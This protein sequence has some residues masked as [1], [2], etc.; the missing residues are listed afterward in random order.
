MAIPATASIDWG[1]MFDNGS[2]LLRSVAKHQTTTSVYWPSAQKSLPINFISS[3]EPVLKTPL[4]KAWCGWLPNRFRSLHKC[5][6]STGSTSKTY[7]RL[8]RSTRLFKFH[9]PVDSTRLHRQ[10]IYSVGRFDR[11]RGLHQRD[12]MFWLIGP[13]RNSTA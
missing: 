3:A 12:G 2:G 9:W 5:W 4:T 8:D 1:W 6:K 13:W 10:T 7:D 11:F